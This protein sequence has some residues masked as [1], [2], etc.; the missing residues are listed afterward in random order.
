MPKYPYVQEYIPYT[1]NIKGDVIPFKEP[2]LEIGANKLGYAV[3]KNPRKAMAL[4]KKNYKNGIKLIAKEYHLLPLSQFN[5]E[6][7]G[8]L[9]CQVTIG[10]KEEK[11][12]ALF[13]CSFMD[14][15][16]NSYKGS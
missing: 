12:E 14:I 9:G 1:G 15:Y 11:N 13:I 8:S 3:F 16:E 5:Y 7:Y 4:L 10:S 2:E 6:K